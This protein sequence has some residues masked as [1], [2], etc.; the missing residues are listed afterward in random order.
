MVLLGFN[1]SLSSSWYPVTR[2]LLVFTMILL[3]FYYSPSSSW[4]TFSMILLFFTWF[5]LRFY[6]FFMIL[7]SFQ[8]LC[9]G[10]AEPRRVWQS[11]AEPGRGRGL[12]SE[13]SQMLSHALTCFQTLYFPAWHSGIVF[14]NVET[15]LTLAPARTPSNQNALPVPTLGQVTGSACT[16]LD[17]TFL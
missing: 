5:F 7:L 16:A 8:N 4:D 10:P 9:Q 13:R 3:C 15:H 17:V 14:R 11:L 2:I 6:L 12:F 1:Y